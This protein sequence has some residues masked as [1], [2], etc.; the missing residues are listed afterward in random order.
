MS[1]SKP[2]T[3][4]VIAYLA[5]VIAFLLFLWFFIV[6]RETISSLA[7]ALLGQ[8]LQETK[9]QEFIN[10]MYTFLAGLA[11][12]VVMITTE[13]YFRTGVQKN[14]LARRI[15]R[16]IGV[17]VALIFLADFILALLIGFDNLAALRWVILIV[18][19]VAAAAL[20]WLGYFKLKKTP[21]RAVGIG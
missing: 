18:E 17:E 10:R 20:I 12:L 3:Q 14:D 6:S 11:W 19:L 4:Y 8:S 7:H 15:S 5:W 13:S 21:R 9:M 16:F 1:Q 2:W